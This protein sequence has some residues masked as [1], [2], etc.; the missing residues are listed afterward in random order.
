VTVRVRDVDCRHVRSV[1]ESGAEQRVCGVPL[2]RRA[3]VVV[4]DLHEGHV[5]VDI[6]AAGTLR[7]RDSRACTSTEEPPAASVIVKDITVT[8]AEP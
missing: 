2:V 7:S 4:V 3:A 8:F 5:G 1:K 6:A